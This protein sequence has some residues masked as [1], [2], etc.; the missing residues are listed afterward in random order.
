MMTDLPP[1]DQPTTDCPTVVSLGSPVLLTDP[2]GGVHRSDGVRR[3]PASLKK[4]FLCGPGTVRLYPKS[5]DNTIE[6]PPK[7][8]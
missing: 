7:V 1:P 5:D 8:P 4:C 6:L 3:R 2:G